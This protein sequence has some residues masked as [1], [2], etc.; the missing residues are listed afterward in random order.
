MSKEHS[1]RRTLKNFRVSLKSALLKENRCKPVAGGETSPFLEAKTAN[2]CSLLHRYISARPQVLTAI[3]ARPELTWRHNQLFYARNLS[4][5]TYPWMNPAWKVWWSNVPP[6]SLRERLPS[7]KCGCPKRLE[8]LPTREE[9][10]WRNRERGEVEP[11][12]RV[13]RIHT[14]SYWVRRKGWSCYHK[15]KPT[16]TLEM[17]KTNYSLLLNCSAQVSKKT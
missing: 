3:Q 9:G 13:S 1:G 8:N 14:R 6:R 15:P 2:L 4:F 12:A 16:H 11:R 10:Q 7:R 17:Q 5:S